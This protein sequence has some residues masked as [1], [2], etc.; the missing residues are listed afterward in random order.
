MKVIKDHLTNQFEIA[1]KC[2]DLLL[3][4]PYQDRKNTINLIQH[5]NIFCWHCGIG[6]LNHPN[7]RCQCW[8][9]E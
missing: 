1:D 5:N 8:N 6:E 4:L 2:I 3:S 7:A 9:D